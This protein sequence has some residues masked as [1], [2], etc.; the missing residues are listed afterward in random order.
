MG[1]GSRREWRNWTL[2]M[3][4]YVQTTSLTIRGTRIGC[5]VTR[6][7]AMGKFSRLRGSVRSGDF[8]LRL[9]TNA[10]AGREELD[11]PFSAGFAQ[12]PR[13]IRSIPIYL[14][15]L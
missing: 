14:H 12:H 13:T 3:Y 1:I 9:E 4:V 2:S 11:L 10:S 7:R 5:L 15:A 8:G 6:V